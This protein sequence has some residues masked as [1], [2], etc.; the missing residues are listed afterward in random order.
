MFGD[1]RQRRVRQHAQGGRRH[2]GKEHGERGREHAA[3]GKAAQE[4]ES[5]VSDAGNERSENDQQPLAHALR[6]QVDRRIDLDSVG[7]NLL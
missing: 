5:R 6:Q 7:R 3:Q 2:G 1:L 4:K